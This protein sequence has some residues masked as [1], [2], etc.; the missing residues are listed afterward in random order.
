MGQHH[1]A[2][3]DADQT[4]DRMP[5]SF[6]HASHLTVAP[7]RDGHAVPAV[8]AFAAAILDRAELGRAVLE[9]HAVQ[10]FLLFILAQS[11]QDTHGILALQTKTRVHELIGQLTR[12]GEEQQSFCVEVQA[13]HR[14]PF[15]VVKPRQLAKNRGAVLRIVMA[16]DLACGLVVS[17]HAGGRRVNADAD[18]LAVH[19]DLVAVLHTLPYVGRLIVDSDAAFRDEFF[20][21]KA[22]TH[23]SLGQDFVQLGRVGLRREHALAQVLRYFFAWLFLIELP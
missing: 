14:L 21:L 9:H 19:L 7:L 11:T 18:R 15:P 2:V 6:H 5:H 20:H 1:R 17:D 3:A 16:D 8:G 10:E 22:R 13:T 4:T 12:T 23:A